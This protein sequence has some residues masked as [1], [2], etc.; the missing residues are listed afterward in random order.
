MFKSMRVTALA[1]ALMAA[2]SIT[3]VA[4]VVYHRGNTADPET[5]D[6]HKTSTTYEAHILRDLY[7]GL[8]AYGADGQIIPGVASEWKVSDDGKTY[9]FMLRDDAKWSNGDPVVAGDFVFS[10][11]RIMNPETGAKYANV[12]YPILNAEK[13]NKGEAKPEELG[14]KALDDHTLEIAL[15]SP[16]P[17]FIDLLGHQTGLPVHPASVEKFGSDFVKAENIVTNGAFT[18][19][20]F[21]PN[22][23]VKAVKN[24][25]FH[26]ADQVKIDTVF[27]YPTE[28]RGA[29][30]RR[31]QAGELHT[32]NDAPTEQVAFM[33]ENLGDQFHVAPYLGTYYYAL[34]HEDEVLKNPDV[35]QALSMAIDREFLADEIWGSTMVAGY[36]FVP[37]GIGN[38]GEPAYADY[39]DMSQIDREEKAIE[40][41]TNA[42]FGPDNPVELTINYNTS[43]NHKNTAVA[44]ADMWKPLGVNVKLINTDTKTHYAMLRDR[45]DFDV[46]RAGWIGDYSDPQ[47]FLFMV[48]SDNDGF[49]YARY[50]NPEYDALMDEAAVTVDLEKRADILKKAEELFMRD[51]PF[52]PMMYYGSM[53]LVSDKMAGF[54]DNLL[55]IHPSRWMSISE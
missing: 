52:I 41:L 47:N 38:Y 42:G 46:A 4:E 17:Y 10:L 40:L 25:H 34:N 5:L 45:Q 53:N 15:E 16:T 50:N 49:N 26:D 37:P 22:A 1:A 9:T 27:F 29:A 31:F 20:E 32:N 2:T 6:Q 7:E 21:V 23:H 12:L 36:S 11:Q 54:E 33:R 24:P 30:L 51:L 48:E 35:R 18:L 19:A 43:E 13:V 3:A 39:K 28:D 55:N 44:I 8:V 14:V